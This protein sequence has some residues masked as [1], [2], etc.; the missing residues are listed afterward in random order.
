MSIVVVGSVA[1]DQI[2]TQYG[3]VDKVLGGSATYFSLAASY[4][5]E[6]RVVAVVGQDFT[7]EHE[8]VLKR[9]GICTQGIQHT[10]GQTFFWGGEYGENLNEAKTKFTHLNVFQNFNPQI[11]AEYADSEFLFWAIS[12]RC[13]RRTCG[14]KCPA[15]ASSAATP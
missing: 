6:V 10:E 5:T 14:G 4:F 11:P 8:Q 7:T 13:C 15:L 9:R 3:Q 2:K 12:T 1:F